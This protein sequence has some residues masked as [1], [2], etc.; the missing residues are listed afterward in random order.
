MFLLAQIREVGTGVPC[1]GF[2]SKQVTK[3]LGK[4]SASSALLCAHGVI[5]GFVLLV[6]LEKT[7]NN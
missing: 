1:P 4:S 3:D 5:R 2:G 6:F 7:P